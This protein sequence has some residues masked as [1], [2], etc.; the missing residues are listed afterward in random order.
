MELSE[1]SMADLSAAIATLSRKMSRLQERTP[2]NTKEWEELAFKKG[3]LGSEMERRLNNIN[4]PKWK[5]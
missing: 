2:E 1:L 5:Q 3:C 4:Y